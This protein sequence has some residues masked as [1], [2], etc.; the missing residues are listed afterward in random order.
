MGM[1]FLLLVVATLFLRPAEII[2]DLDEWPIYEVLILGTIACS[3]Q[4]LPEYLRQRN[5]LA[6][7]MSFCIVAMFVAAGLS[8]A[9]TANLYALRND[10]ITLAKAMMLYFLVLVQV[11]SPDRYRA[12]LLTVA[13]CGTAM[14]SI[15]VLDYLEIVDFEFITHV[16]DRDGFD[17]EEEMSIIVLR[18]RGTGLFEDPN[19]I[20]L[21]IVTAGLLCVYFLTHRE[22]FLPRPVWILMLAVLLLGLMLTRSRGGVLSMGAGIVTLLTFKYGKWPAIF[23]VLCAIL[24]VPLLGGRQGEIDL[25]GGTGQERVQLW[26][27]GYDEL[28]SSAIVF[29]TGLNTY[30]DI[31]GLVAHNSFVH[32][33]VELG[34]IG[35]T[36]FFGI[37]FFA[38][39][40]LLKLWLVRHEIENQDLLRMQPFLIAI[41]LAWVIGFMSL[42]RAYVTPTFL[43]F[44]MMATYLRMIG[45][46]LKPVRPVLAIDTRTVW[47]WWA[48]SAAMFVGL[49]LFIKIFVRF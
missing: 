6:N 25:E 47:Q 1:L 10:W 9:S 2:P 31:V 34:F 45:S 19:D 16:A 43:V 8:L 36:C 32:T 40:G 21:V 18:M 14:V 15:C 24:A 11:R 35:G 44:G 33:Y 48:G 26:A 39:Y 29:G 5:L 23:G 27:E 4:R 22:P 13:I 7:P 46:R 38:L 30:S 12:L 3:A 20:S 42:S 49:W 41:T 28:K 17:E 37:F